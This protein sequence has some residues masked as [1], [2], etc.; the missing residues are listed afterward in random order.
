MHERSCAEPHDDAAGD[1]RF[2]AQQK[3]LEHLTEARWRTSME[4]G[5]GLRR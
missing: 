5:G 1:D 2:I 4:V 3:W